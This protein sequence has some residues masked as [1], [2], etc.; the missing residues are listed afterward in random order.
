MPIF[1]L[2]IIGGLTAAVAVASY[3]AAKKAQKAAKRPNDEQRG[4]L[5]NKESNVEQLPV[6]Y[7]VRRVGGVRV[8]VSTDGKYKTVGGQ[9]DWYSGYHPDTDTYDTTTSTPTNEYLYVALALCEG[10]VQDITDIL[11]DDIPATDP[12]YAGLVNIN[13]YK[14]SDDQTNTTDD[15]GAADVLTTSS[16][17]WTS[18]HRLRGVAYLGMRFKWDE[19]AFSGIP[20]VTALVTGKKVYDPRTDTTAWSDNPALCVRDYLTN[21]RYGKGLPISAIDDD[22]IEQ[23]ANDCDESVTE[24]SGGTTGKLFTCNAVLDTSKTLFDNLNILLLGCRGFLPYS[25]GQYRLKIDGSSASQFTFTKDHIIGGIG[26]SGESKEE[27][28]NRVTVKFPNPDANWQPD[29]ATWPP[30][31]STEETTYLA[32][33]GGVLLQEDIDLDTITSY[34]QARDLARVI[35]LRSRNAIT[36]SIKTTSEALQLEIADVVSI[37]HPTPGWTAKP[38]QITQMQLNE[39]GTVTLALL[40]YDSTIYTWEV[41]TE[42]TAYPDTNL[43]DPFTVAAVSN[44]TI[45]ET[46]T[47]GLSLIHI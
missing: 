24:Y 47:L 6:I 2:W 21:T 46:T 38:F 36:C 11:I 42:Q 12:K 39:D 4:V 45:T 29:T 44:I 27:K 20:E 41:G 17:D 43:P 23:A 1:A 9:E 26:I 40:E 18:D 14:G 15:L 19:E 3:T 33:D 5:V 28:L 34:Y 16:E 30:A 31:G 7:G 37:T 25:Q 10:E 32:E 22:A 13:V 35:L 8:F